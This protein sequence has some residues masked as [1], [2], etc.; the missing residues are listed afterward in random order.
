MQVGNDPLWGSALDGGTPACLTSYPLLQKAYERM[1]NEEACPARVDY[2]RPADQESGE[3]FDQL[4]LVLEQEL[5]DHQVPNSERLLKAGGKTLAYAAEDASVRWV[6]KVD[7]SGY[8]AE[9]LDVGMPTGYD[10]LDSF[11]PK[12]F[13][14]QSYFIAYAQ[15]DLI[16]WDVFAYYLEDIGVQELQPYGQVFSVRREGNHD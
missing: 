5:A 4:F 11:E 10:L 12:Y 2:L 13:K 6:R 16:L 1:T 3:E 14:D 9:C 7:W 8:L 15:V